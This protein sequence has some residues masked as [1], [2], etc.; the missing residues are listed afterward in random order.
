MCG[1]FGYAVKQS[2]PRLGQV[3]LQLA[4][5]NESRGRVSFGW[6]DGDHL[7][8]DLGNISRKLYLFPLKQHGVLMG[9]TRAPTVGAH[10]VENSHPYEFKDKHHVIGAHNGSIYN[11]SELNKKYNRTLDVDSMH[12]FA[13]IAEGHPLDDLEGRGAITFLKD[14]ELCLSR[15]NSGSLAV[16]HLT[17]GG[18][19]WSSL[20][21]DL[22]K[23]LDSANLKY[24]IYNLVEGNIYFYGEGD[25]LYNSNDKITIQVSTTTTKR[26]I[27]NGSSY[28][29]I[30]NSN[31]SKLP[32][33][34]QRNVRLRVTKEFSQS[35]KPLGDT[36][37][38]RD[39]NTLMTL[40]KDNPGLSYEL[41]E[42]LKCSHC[43][44]QTTRRLQQNNLPCCLRCL[45]NR[46]YNNEFP[47]VNVE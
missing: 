46:V 21:S 29:P 17:D 14:G 25:K 12:I 15:F 22:R 34:K 45:A 13:H 8:K 33:N 44:E 4:L 6:S 1:L 27:N 37:S 20:D 41:K 40:H 39:I 24:T 5:E 26:F 36:V 28:Y 42:L 11:H 23:C 32:W 31:D 35:P 43:E 30:T 7:V 3:L 19:V 38:T 47:V 2:I 16:A 18:I 9:H 10:I